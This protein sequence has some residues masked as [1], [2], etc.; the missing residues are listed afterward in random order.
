MT[1]ST[2]TAATRYGVGPRAVYPSA[3]PNA[4]EVPS[5]VRAVVRRLPVARSVVERVVGSV[6]SVRTTQGLLALTFDDGPDP[7]LTPRVAAALEARGHRGTFFV[8]AA[9]VDA[10]PQVVRQLHAHG[11]QIALHGDVHHRLTSASR[12]EVW[13]ATS[14]A[15]AR[16][17]R[18]LGEPLRWFRPP[19]GAQRVRELAMARLARL[20]V[21]VWSVGMRDWEDLG[22][23]EEHLRL[24]EGLLVP[25]AVVCL[26]DV[27]TASMDAEAK[28]RLLDA[29]LDALDELGL[30]SVTLDELLSAGA[31]NRGIW[32]R[33]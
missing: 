16:V 27:E 29:L 21:A 8:L 25:G 4:L 13:A 5:R 7:E 26:H 28:L 18:H 1:W 20:D 30:R 22:G 31:P 19:H 23:P 14:G 2:R 15:R 12:R 32:L 10:A 11:H 9:A 6:T 24:A 3:V 17:E 33:R